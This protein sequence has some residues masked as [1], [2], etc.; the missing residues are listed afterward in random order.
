MTLHDR[1]DDAFRAWGRWVFRWRRPIL[2]GSLV[3]AAGLFSLLPELRFD[4]SMESGLLREDPA[5]ERYEAFQEQFGQDQT[6]LLMLEPQA[7]FDRSFLEKLRALHRDLERDVPY[8]EQVTSLIN[9][10]DIR[11]EGDRLV[12]GGLL[13]EWPRT[14]A[15]LERL[16]ERVLSNSFYRNNLVNDSLTLTVVI[17]KPLLDSPGSASASELIA[18]GG[19]GDASAAPEEGPQ[20]LSEEQTAEQLAAIRQVMEKHDA[21][22]LSL[23]LGG[24]PVVAEHLNEIISRDAAFSVAGSLLVNVLV[25]AFLFRRISGVVMPVLVVLLALL[26]TFGIMAG[27]DL[28][29]SPTSSILPRFLIVVGLCNAIHLLTRVYR[30]VADGSGKEEALSDSLGETGLPILMASVTTAGSVL[31]FTTTELAQTVNLGWSAALGVLIASVYSLL[32]LP[33][34]IAVTPVSRKTALGGRRTER[35]IG[36]LLAGIGDVATGRPRTVLIVTAAVV[37]LAATGLPRLRFAQETLKWFPSGDPTRRTM[38]LMDREFGGVSLELLVRTGRDNGLYAPD[39]LRRMDRSQQYAESLDGGAMKVVKATSLV[40]VVKETHAALQNDPG[41]YRIPPDRRA[42]AQELLLFAN[43]GL[44]HREE[45][46]DAPYRTARMTF[47]IPFRDPVLVPPFVEELKSGIGTILG[48][49]ASVEFTG[50]ADLMAR[51]MLLINTSMTKSYILALVIITPLMILMIGSVK[52]G[53]LAMIPNLIPVILVLGFMGWQDIPLDSS[54]LLLGC[55]ILGLAVDDTIHFMYTLRRE[56]MR[57]PDVR[58][59]IHRTLGTTGSALLCTTAVLTLGFLVAVFAYLNNVSTF[60]ILAAGATGSAFFAD[61][62]VA[63]AL[64]SLLFRDP[65][66]RSPA[67]DRRRRVRVERPWGGHRCVQKL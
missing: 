19:S 41:D 59:A 52:L 60:G 43:A 29:M 9:A 8:L 44:Q 3:A 55:V 37:A 38:E 42:V 15:D 34:L 40:D 57:G 12:V 47:R 6:F 22:G 36:R 32:F 16:R 25:L 18:D 23:R 49:T 33:A 63:P 54:T 20:E 58:T 24:I 11:A 2:F 67:P 5:I 64:I 31:A 53:L 10:R 61:V 27:V 28:P 30:R 39:L 51:S 35:A 26:S 50:M 66:R 7:I 17:L 1:T 4:S 21:E 65:A 45:L 48:D 56:V 14:E 46:V 13:D 62:L